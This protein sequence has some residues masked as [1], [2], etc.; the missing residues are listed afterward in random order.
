MI[1]YKSNI[2][3]LFKCATEHPDYLESF[4]ILNKNYPNRKWEFLHFRPGF[5]G[6]LDSETSLNTIDVYRNFYDHNWIIRHE[7]DNSTKKLII[8]DNLGDI[9]YYLNI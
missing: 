1:I 5:S 8:L 3:N 2:Y 9:E 4:Y 7:I 6:V